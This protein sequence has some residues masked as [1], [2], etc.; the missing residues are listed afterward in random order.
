MLRLPEQLRRR[1]RI[2]KRGCWLHSG[3]KNTG[4]Y[5]QLSFNGRLWLAHRLVWTLLVGRIPKG[6]LVLHKCPGRHRHCVN[7][8][9]LYVGTYA[10]NR[11][12]E[13]FDGTDH[14]VL[15]TRCPKGHP[16][17][18]VNTYIYPNG[19]RACRTCLR[20]ANLTWYHRKM[21][22]PKWRAAEAAEARARRADKRT[23]AA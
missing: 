16:Y 21:K 15:K 5:H 20:Q 6:M 1:I 19:K 9:H 14:N 11:R 23:V 4:G 22:D 2:G 18:K 3:S 17:S 13:R 8:A 10:D 7:P 12:D